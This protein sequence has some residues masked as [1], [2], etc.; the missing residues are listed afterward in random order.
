MGLSTG[1]R[2]GPYE[3]LSPLGAGGMGEVY[4]ARDTRLE[5]TVA[6]KVLSATLNANLEFKQ[7]LE[8]EA[9]AI[10][11]LQ[12]PHICVLHD[13]GHQDGT[14]FLVMEYLEG[15]TLSERLKRGPLPMEQF[16]KIA[17]QV[18][19]ALD[20]AH[21]AGIVHR[22]LKPGNIMLT[23]TGAKLLDFGLAKPAGAGLA[24][25]AGTSPSQSVF[26]AAMTRSSPASPLTSAGSI[27]GTVQYMAPEQIEGKEADAR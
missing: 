12:H 22:D 21:R 14:D 4:R 7:R 15:E 27:V 17:I 3:I 24:A 18:A 23:K 13:V 2:L 10:S 25:A 1:T 11:A 26:S 19:D 16:W 9:K 8:R 5:R 20:K 6:I